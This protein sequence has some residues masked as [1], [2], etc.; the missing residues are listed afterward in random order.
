VYGERYVGDCDGAGADFRDDVDAD[1]IERDGHDY[2][3]VRGEPELKEF[4]M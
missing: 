2:V 3:H 4:P 1:A